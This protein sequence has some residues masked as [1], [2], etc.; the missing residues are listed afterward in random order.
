MS[1]RN[2]LSSPALV[3]KVYSLMLSTNRL[4]D[5][6]GVSANRRSDSADYFLGQIETSSE[7]RQSYSEQPAYSAVLH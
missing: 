5:T 1:H 2:L 6:V 3:A 7:Q 4:A